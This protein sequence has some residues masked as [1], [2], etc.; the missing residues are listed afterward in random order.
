MNIG[1]YK[2]K[3][4]FSDTS[5]SIEAQAKICREYANNS[6]KITS[7]VEYEDEGFTGANI[8]RPGY[9]SLIND[10]KNKKIDVLICYKIDRI[11]RNV[12]DFSSTFNILQESNVQFVSVKEQIDTSTP[13]GRAMMYICSVFAQMERETIAERV[14]DSLI[15][16]AKSGKWAGGK[17]PVGYKRERII[18]NGKQHTTLVKKDEDQKYLNTIFDT[19]LEG[20]SLNGLETHFKNIGMKTINGNYLSSTQIYQILK[21]PHYVSATPIIYDYFKNL[22]CVMACDKEKFTSDCGVIVYGRTSGGKKKLHSVNSPEKWIVSVGLHKPL[23]S[24]EKW[25]A[26]QNRFN[27]NSIDKTRK[28]D[29]GLLKGVLKCKCGY[30]MRVQHK[31]DNKYNK[32]YDNYYCQNRNRRGKSFCDLSMVNVDKLDSNFLNLLKKL[33]ADKNLLR[34]YINQP[35]ENSKVSHRDRES[36]KKD[37]SSINKKIQNLTVILQENSE[38]S[39]SKYIISE[40]ENLDKKMIGLNFEL[41]ELEIQEQ[42]KNSNEYNVDVIYNKIQYYV[43]NFNSLTYNEKTKCIQDF[44]KECVWDGNKLS[45]TI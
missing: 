36:I 3:S 37:I 6:F 35:L 30:S 26:V 33:S 13:L 42:N 38:S 27:K 28:H 20:Y 18:V 43:N 23:I 7:V 11:S 5:D 17:A 40:I 1:I 22:G 34:Q 44:V 12:L 31:V 39:A 25:L 19:F 29:I 41:R 16:L 14:K 4:L 24:P 10:V 21:N 32:I 15:E 2:R 9:K 8:D 45:V